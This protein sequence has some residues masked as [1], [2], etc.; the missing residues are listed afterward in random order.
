MNR[1]GPISTVWVLAEPQGG[2]WLVCVQSPAE[3]LFQF[4]N[5]EAAIKEGRAIAKSTK[6]TLFFFGEGGRPDFKESYAG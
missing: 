6:A 5:C 3:P 1:T 4:Q 2:G